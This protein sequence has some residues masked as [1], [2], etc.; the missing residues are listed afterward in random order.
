MGAKNTAD[1][2][3]PVVPSREA[4]MRAGGAADGAVDVIEVVGT[5]KWFDVG[6]GFGRDRT[7]VLYACHLVEDMRED[8][9]FDRIIAMTERVA[10]AAL[11]NRGGAY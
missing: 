10:S 2:E 6:K 1:G 9:E 3:E 7:T 11:R 5:I 8:Q 4:E